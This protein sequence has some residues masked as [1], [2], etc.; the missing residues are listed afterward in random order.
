MTFSWFIDRKNNIC[1]LGAV[2]AAI[3]VD[4]KVISDLKDTFR[5]DIYRKYAAWKKE[6]KQ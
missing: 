5:H 4:G 1:G 6:Q 2:Q 3:P